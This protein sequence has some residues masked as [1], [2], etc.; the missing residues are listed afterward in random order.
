MSCED[1]DYAQS[2]LPGLYFYLSADLG[3][4]GFCASGRGRFADDVHVVGACCTS[5]AG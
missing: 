1:A 2:H 4:L 3:P 5:K